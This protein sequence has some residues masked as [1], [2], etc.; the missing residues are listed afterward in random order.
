MA[1]ERHTIPGWYWIEEGYEGDGSCG[2]FTTQEAALRHAQSNEA[3]EPYTV[4]LSAHD[5]CL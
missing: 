5:L 4:Y 1:N 2:P 3:E